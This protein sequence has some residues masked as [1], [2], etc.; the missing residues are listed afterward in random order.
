MASLIFQGMSLGIYVHIMGGFDSQ[1]ARS[2]LKIPERFDP[3]AMFALGYPAKSTEGFEK[4]LVERE[5]RPRKRKD[6]NEILY[7][8]KWGNIK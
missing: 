1:L 4:E 2:K 7:I 6:I 8:G 5:L 3:V